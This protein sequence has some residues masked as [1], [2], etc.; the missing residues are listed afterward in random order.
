MDAP[1]EQPETWAEIEKRLLA[2]RDSIEITPSPA[3]LHSLTSCANCQFATK[4]IRDDET[5]HTCGNPQGRDYGKQSDG[6]GR[7]TKNPKICTTTLAGCPEYRRGTPAERDV[8][9]H[10]RRNMSNKTLRSFA[11]ML[12]LLS[13]GEFAVKLDEAMS[14]A[15]DALEIMPDDVG[16]AEINVKVVLRYEL[17]RI[18]IDPK[19]TVKLPETNRFMKTPFWAH[20]GALSLEHP[21]QI[22]MFAGPRKVD[23]EDAEIVEEVEETAEG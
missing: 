12:G 23:A 22:D 8:F 7:P 10:R 13:R 9:N 6:Q 5:R 3:L 1:V 17:G 19:F 2:D 14:E 11:Q 20:D 4:W 21:N 15:I 16:K 18:D